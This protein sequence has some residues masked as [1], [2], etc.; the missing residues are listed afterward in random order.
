MPDMLYYKHWFMSVIVQGK[1]DIIQAREG[2]ILSGQLFAGRLSF[3]V[4]SDGEF[5][6]R[7]RV[8]NILQLTAYSPLQPVRRRCLPEE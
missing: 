2:L 5:C 1:N 6:L 4:L 3:P 8:R 7:R